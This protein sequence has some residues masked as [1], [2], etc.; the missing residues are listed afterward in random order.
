MLGVIIQDKDKD[1][2]VVG[3][4][5]V[6]ECRESVQMLSPS[7]A[8]IGVRTE[9]RQM[10]ATS[11]MVIH[12]GILETQGGWQWELCVSGRDRNEETSRRADQL[13]GTHPPGQRYAS[14]LR[15]TGQ[16]NYM[17]SSRDGGSREAILAYDHLPLIYSSSPGLP[18]CR[19]ACPWAAI[20][21]LP[22]LFGPVCGFMINGVHLALPS[23]RIG[24]ACLLGPLLCL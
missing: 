12:Q 8:V 6:C 23:H 22:Y 9:L 16:Q 19:L 7:R 15:H 5:T 24:T 4:R 14:Q 17:D 20:V 18:M 1:N 3:T 10:Q 21:W 13:A 2:K 11:A